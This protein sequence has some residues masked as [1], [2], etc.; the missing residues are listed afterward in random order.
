MHQYALDY[1]VLLR[2]A[3][4]VDQSRIRVV[5]IRREGVLHPVGSH[6]GGIVLYFALHE[7][8]DLDTANG[9]IDDAHPVAVGKVLQ[10]RAA[11]IVGRRHS[12]AVTAERRQSLVPLAHDTARI[13]IV[14]SREGEVTVADSHGVDMLGTCRALHVGLSETEEDMKIR[15]LCAGRYRKAQGKQRN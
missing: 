3:G 4:H 1:S 6:V 7:A 14:D 12:V 9:D 10:H 11:E 2:D 15:I 13:L 5:V 8:F